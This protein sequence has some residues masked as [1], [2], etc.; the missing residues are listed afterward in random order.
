[1][2]GAWG[3]E[4][5]KIQV[6]AAPD[7]DGHCSLASP[8]CPRALL[9]WTLSAKELLAKDTDAVQNGCSTLIL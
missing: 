3:A 2:V 9:E 6:Q 8:G 4:E 5:E 1:M 7:Y